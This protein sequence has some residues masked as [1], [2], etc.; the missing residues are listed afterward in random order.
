M[1]NLDLDFVIDVAG[2][3]VQDIAPDEMDMQKEIVAAY[4]NDPKGALSNGGMTQVG[5]GLD[6]V[7]PLIISG[8]SAAFAYLLDKQMEDAMDKIKARLSKKKTAQDAASEVMFTPEQFRAIHKAV[9]DQIKRMDKANDS[10]LDPS[11]IADAIIGK[12]AIK[13]AKSA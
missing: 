7:T 6:L 4:K 11:I 1:S 3:I 9:R 5:A 13:E 12:L 10:T 8:V 2:Q